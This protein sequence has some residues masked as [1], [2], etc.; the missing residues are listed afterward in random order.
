MSEV[1]LSYEV[2]VWRWWPTSCFPAFGTVS[3]PTSRQAV[4]A[5]LEG[6][7][8]TRVAR[9]AVQSPDGSMERWVHVDRE[10]LRH[11]Q[12]TVEVPLVWRHGRVVR[13][14]HDSER[15]RKETG[16]GQTLS[17]GSLSS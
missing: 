6:E 12:V 15:E 5:F 13:V 16:H 10:A 8:M 2:A 11:G 4:L 1:A 17:G 7:K 3:A 9:V 14:S